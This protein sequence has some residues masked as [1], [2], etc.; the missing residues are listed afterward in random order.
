MS[1]G[2]GLVLYCSIAFPFAI[3]Y[4]VYEKKITLPNAILIVA[5]LAV[6]DSLIYLRVA[7]FHH[8][9]TVRDLIIL[10]LAVFISMFFSSRAGKLDLG[11]RWKDAVETTRR[12]RH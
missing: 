5:I 10:T 3:A 7:Y 11:K 4:M 2:E 8:S 12:R 6:L 9:E 1:L